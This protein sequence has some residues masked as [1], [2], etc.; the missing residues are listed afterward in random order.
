[1]PL[2]T[3][4]QQPRSATE[5]LLH[6]NGK[7]I[8]TEEF[9]YL[10][11]KNNQHK[12]EEFTREKIEEYFQ[13]FINYKLKVEEAVARGLDT[14]AAFRREYNTYRQELLKP[15]LPDSKVIDSLVLLTY[16]RLKQEVNASHILISLR[17][18]AAPEDTL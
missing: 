18:D 17:P 1:I 12:P 14:T 11:R 8:T 5:T 6:I 3:N 16:E 10:Y 13:L 2:L 7:P 15:Y 9:V 4:A